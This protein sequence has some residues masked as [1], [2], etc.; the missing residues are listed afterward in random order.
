MLADWLAIPRMTMFGVFGGLIAE[1]KDHRELFDIV[2]PDIG[3]AGVVDGFHR[4]SVSHFLPEDL[5][6]DVVGSLTTLRERGYFVV[7]AGNQ[8]IEQ[9]AA[10]QAMNLPS[11]LLA[12]SA[13]W[14]VQ[15]PDLLYLFIISDTFA[16]SSGTRTNRRASPIC[17]PVVDADNSNLEPRAEWKSQHQSDTVANGIRRAQCR[18]FGLHF[19][20]LLRNL[21]LFL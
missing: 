17:L 4:S 15:K 6:P 21:S 14:G 20:Q 18:P 12:T 16:I 10:L 3:W 7:I 5:Y 8:P 1:R 11:D 19:G 13:G 2:R 9:E